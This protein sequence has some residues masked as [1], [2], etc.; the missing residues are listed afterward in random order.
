M[1][2][3]VREPAPQM[4]AMLP[5]DLALVAD[6]ERRSYEFP[7]SRGIFRDC[8]LAGYT[9]LVIEAEGE[10]R[11]YGILSVAAGE[12]HLLNLCVDRHWRRYGFGELLLAEVISRARNATV[13]QILLEV[14]PSNEAALRLYR[15]YGFRPIGR[16]RGYY[17]ADDGR[18]DAMVLALR[19]IPD[20]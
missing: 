20:A 18:E 12:A 2:S 8:L 4:R 1:N 11:G 15:K 14:R 16:R 19:L 10:P 17:R 3:V 6:I 13:R 7:W 5:G 9:C